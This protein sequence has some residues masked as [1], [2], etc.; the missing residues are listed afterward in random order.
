MTTFFSDEN[1]VRFKWELLRDY[2]TACLYLL[3]VADTLSNCVSILLII[4]LNDE[5]HPN[6]RENES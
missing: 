3:L 1:D 2:F 4:R 6:A 5:K